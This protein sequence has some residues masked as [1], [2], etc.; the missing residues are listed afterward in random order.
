MPINGSDN[1]PA[2][3]S[4]CSKGNATTILHS[5]THA[6]VLAV[7][8]VATAVTAA[9]AVAVVAVV[10]DDAVVDFVPVVVVAAVV[11]VVVACV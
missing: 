10:D 5:G 3:S 2:H 8:D 9:F 4:L 11:V 6:V 7:I 1:S